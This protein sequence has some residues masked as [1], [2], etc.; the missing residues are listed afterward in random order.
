MATAETESCLLLFKIILLACINY[1]KVVHCDIS[2]RLYI[3]LWSNLLHYSFLPLRPSPSISQ[4]LVGSVC[5]FIHTHNVL[6]SASVPSPFS[7]SF[8]PC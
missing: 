1:T 2:I 6:S 4:M 5:Y 8:P 7:F 3:V